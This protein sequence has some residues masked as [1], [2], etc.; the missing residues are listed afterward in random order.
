MDDVIRRFLAPPPI[1][2]RAEVMASP[3]P[4][5]EHGGVYGW[6]FRRLP[7]DLD[8]K[9][10]I[11]HDGLTLLYVGISPKE[12]PAR[13]DVPSRATLRSRIRTHY[14]GNAEG[15]T[16]RRTLG[17][18]LAGT[19][20][21]ELRCVGTGKRFTFVEGE[22][23]LSSWMD[24]NALVSWVPCDRPWEV[25]EEL[26]RRLDLPLNLEGNGPHPFRPQLSRIRSEAV[27]R[28]KELPVVENPGIGG[29]RLELPAVSGG[30]F[31]AR[32]ERAAVAGRVP[33]GRLVLAG[34]AA[35]A[36]R[37]S[38]E[39]SRAMLAAALHALRDG[40]TSLGI[41]VTPAGFVDHKPGGF[42]GGSHG[43][44]TTQSDF[45][46]LAASAAGVAADLVSPDV[47]ELARGVVDHLVI[48][49]DIWPTPAD[50]PYGETACLYDVAEG[51]IRVITGKSYPNTGQ[52]DDLIRNPD[53]ASHV[54][55]V[56]D[57]RL[58]VLVCHDLAAWHPRGKKYS[59]GEREQTWR[60]IRVAV[61][62]ARPTLAVQLPHTVRTVRTWAPAWSTFARLAGGSLRA[63]TTAIR[64]LD[65][66]YHAV[67]E[68]LAEPLLAGTGWGSR[69]VDV[70]VEG[71]GGAVPRAA[72]AAPSPPPVH[73]AVQRVAGYGGAYKGKAEGVGRVQAVWADGYLIT[74]DQP[75]GMYGN[76]GRRG[77]PGI[78]C[79]CRAPT[80]R[81]FA[82]DPVR[83]DRLEPVRYQFVGRV[84]DD[85]AGTEREGVICGKCNRAMPSGNA[86]REEAR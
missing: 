38:V 1:R 62:D 26:I 28:A 44:G 71:R 4:V 18:L 37:R 64:H 66:G 7:W 21:L 19:L 67:S 50:K 17:C 27:R 52:Q 34:A 5:P 33:L 45:D 16:L 55:D 53:L 2:T 24:A 72:G 36:D 43:W 3:C 81:L 76:L 74:S 23:R 77:G 46:H 10:C 41:L 59:K 9:G 70:V 49:V 56:G 32:L 79:G 51:T 25:E 22:Q 85:Y 54:V 84:R 78:G 69:V 48:G 57:E 30:R 39:D 31:A 86:G 12:S 35:T 40:G 65:Q 11:T 75:R 68:S 29:R 83:P 47:R 8:T 14:G 60:A 6:W 82:P 58:A 63:G 20:G 80:P 73:R 15:S 42:W 13:G 61:T